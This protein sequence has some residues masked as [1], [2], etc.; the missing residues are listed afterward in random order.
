M[1]TFVKSA[2][3]LGPLSSEMLHKT[4][5]LYW[6][7]LFFVSFFNVI[8][9]CT[10]VFIHAY[11]FCL[12][13]WCALTCLSSWTT[14]IQGRRSQTCLLLYLTIEFARGHTWH[15]DPFY[16]A[17]PC[18]WLGE[19]WKVR[20][21]NVWSSHLAFNLNI[22]LLIWGPSFLTHGSVVDWVGG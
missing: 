6:V 9:C 12:S 10:H 1:Y 4:I 11:S 19:F 14:R 13:V 17:P 18:P 22:C 15:E 7:N 8:K 20:Q 5:V 2:I 16:C 21:H 3:W